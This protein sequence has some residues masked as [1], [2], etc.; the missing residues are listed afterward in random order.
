MPARSINPIIDGVD[1]TPS[2]PMC[3]TTRLSSTVVTISALSPG[4]RRFVGMCLSPVVGALR[5]TRPQSIALF[6]TNCSGRVP[7]AEDQFCHRL[8]HYS[9]LGSPLTLCNLEANRLSQR[10][11]D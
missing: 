11:F 7:Q 5:G 1:S 3:L 4:V 10:F 2:P 9:G 6:G 8:K